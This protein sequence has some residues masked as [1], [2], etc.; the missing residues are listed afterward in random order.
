[1][2]P[3]SQ[4][5]QSEMYS[6]FLLGVSPLGLWWPKPC[7]L[8]GKGRPVSHDPSLS[9]YWASAGQEQ[10]ALPVAKWKKETH[11]VRQFLA[12][13]LV[14]ERRGN[15]KVAWEQEYYVCFYHLLPFLL[16][17][18]L[19]LFDLFSPKSPLPGHNLSHC[20][21]RVSHIWLSWHHLL[22]QRDVVS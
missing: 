18:L 14:R 10:D 11:R 22:G 21:L 4:I 1:M 19:L 13:R 12:G 17:S 20:W 9:N 16:G 3:G 7:R 15:R 8:K 5:S 6:T 2:S